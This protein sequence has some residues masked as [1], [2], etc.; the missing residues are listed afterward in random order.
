MDTNLTAKA[1]WGRSSQPDCVK[2]VLIVED[3]PEASEMLATACRLEGYDAYLAAD[4]REALGQLT[5]GVAPDLILLDLDM[6]VMDGW[7]FRSVQ[8]HH[9][10]WAQIPIVVISTRAGGGRTRD[11]APLAHLAKPVDFDALFAIIRALPAH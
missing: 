8:Q 10:E 11:L 5:A 1:V 7:Q 6:P 3:D 9:R 2:R 4:G